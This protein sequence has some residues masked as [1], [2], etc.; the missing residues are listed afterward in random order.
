MDV[1]GLAHQYIDGEWVEGSSEKS[2]TDRNPYSGVTLAEVPIATRE[3]IDRAYRAAE[4]AQREWRQVNQYDK[5]TFFEKAVRF[6]EDNSGDIATMILEELG[7]TALKAAFETGLVIDIIKEAATFPLRMEGKILP[8]PIDGRENYLY[9]EPVGVV[10]VI[11][12]FNFPFFLSMKGVAPA[13]GAGNAVV[14]KPHEDTLVTGGTLLAK[15]FE[16]AGLPPG[17]LNVVLTD[18]P[19]IGDYFVEHPIPRVIVFT[20]SNAV[21]AHVAEVAGR[22][23]KKPILELGGNNAFIVLEDADIDLAVDAAVF[24]RFTH[25]GQ[26]CMSGNRVLVHRAVADEF[27]DK[28]VAKVASLKV[29]DPAEPDT[30]IGPLI[31]EKQASRLNG[32]VEQAVHAGATALLRGAV[33][34]TMF[35]PAVLTDVTPDMTAY[36]EE[37]FGPAV[38]LIPF[39]SEDEAVRLAND[40]AYGLSGAVHTRDIDRGVRVARQIET[41]MVH[42]NDASI[43]DE[44]IVAFGGAKG[45]G[46]GRL[47]GQWSLDE[48][49]VM[50][51]VSVNRGRRQF[52]Y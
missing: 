46:I 45:S 49:T 50:K 39:D 48:F 33:D 14:L 32:V 15:I 23:L 37:M 3:D 35:A 18:I 27:R 11:S 20:G 51:W 42:V 34:G 16:A 9:R 25:Q 19:A 28:Y 7:G 52:P 12:P 30:I 1:K 24:S 2:L 31:N 26:I 29:G 47:N 22:H 36:K 21:G 10:G 6:V 38:V 4:R 43:H 41:G 40:S 13:L 44:P 8:S 5:R 17:L